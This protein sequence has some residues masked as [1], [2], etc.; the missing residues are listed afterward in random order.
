[1]NSN[2]V[3]ADQTTSGAR[4]INPSRLTTWINFSPHMDQ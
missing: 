1:M 2:T 3:F 4:F